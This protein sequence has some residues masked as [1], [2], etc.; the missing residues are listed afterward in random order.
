MDFNYSVSRYQMDRKRTI[1]F[2]DHHEILLSLTNGGNFFIRKQSYPI[3][4]GALFCLNATEIHHCFS[5]DGLF[6][7]RFVVHFSEQTL[8]NFSTTHTNL[9]SIFKN[10][11]TYSVVDALSLSRMQTQLDTLMMPLPDR[12]AAD[13]RRNNLFI[14]F[15]LGVGEIV[16]TDVGAVQVNA[17]DS[18]RV[19][20]IIDYIQGHVAE[21][22]SREQIAKA[23]FISTP[24]LG[25]IFKNATGFSIGEYIINYRIQRACNMLLQGE[26]VQ[27][28][29]KMVGFKGS[30]HFNRIFKKRMGMSPGVFAHK[31]SNVIP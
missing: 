15:L 17:L 12:F 18:G 7:E 19:T 13:I 25:H 31:H 3:V 26:K 1:H 20:D 4:A 22:L 8:K 24:H 5:Q 30:T 27:D 21:D 28:I 10:A 2:H 16:K 29:G 23:F 11:R 6:V 9:L 14:D